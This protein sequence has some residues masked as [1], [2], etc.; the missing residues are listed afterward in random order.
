MHLEAHGLLPIMIVIGPPA[1][2]IVPSAKDVAY[3]KGYTRNYHGGLTAEIVG[4][5]MRDYP[6]LFFLFPPIKFDTHEMSHT[7]DG[8]KI[9]IK[10]KSQYSRPTIRIINNA[11][12]GLTLRIRGRYYPT[13]YDMLNEVNLTYPQIQPGLER[14]INQVPKPEKRVVEKIVWRDRYIPNK[15][16][17]VTE[18]MEN[19]IHDT[20][21]RM[22]DWRPDKPDMEN[23][24]LID[25]YLEKP[26]KD[27]ISIDE[28]ERKIAGM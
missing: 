19:E 23:V 8:W 17:S 1:A 14:S 12:F 16:Q 11:G 10:Q 7:M 24:I 20:V 9:Q 5:H 3:S 15:I 27:P 18:A 13:V 6:C 28:L 4:A 26:K 2:A 21:M 22:G 25:G